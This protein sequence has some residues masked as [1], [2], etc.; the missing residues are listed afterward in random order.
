MTPLKNTIGL[1]EKG[2]IVNRIGRTIYK[3]VN[4]NKIYQ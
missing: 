1:N 2:P 4:A 3:L